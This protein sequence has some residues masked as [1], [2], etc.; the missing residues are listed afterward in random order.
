MVPPTPRSVRTN[1]SNLVTKVECSPR[2]LVAAEDDDLIPRPHE[3]RRRFE[4]DASCLPSGRYFRL[5]RILLPLYLRYPL[6]LDSLSLEGAIRTGSAPLRMPEQRM[7]EQ[8]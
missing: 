5:T 4:G 2:I 6:K 1:E 3:A 7:E 8:L